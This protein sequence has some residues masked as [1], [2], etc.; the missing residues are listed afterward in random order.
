MKIKDMTSKTSLEVQDTDILVIED[1]QDTKNITVGEFKKYLGIGNDIEIDTK[2]LI[3]QTIDN[4]ISSLASAK[5]V[6]EED[7]TTVFILDVTVED[8]ACNMSISIKNSETDTYLTAEELTNLLLPEIPK[9]LRTIE[10]DQNTGNEEIIENEG[11]TGDTEGDNTENNENT[12]GENNNPEVNNSDSNEPEN[13]ETPDNNESGN[14]EI[15]DNN[16]PGNEVT[17]NDPENSNPEE[18]IPEDDNQ[19][20]DIPEQN[21]PEEDNTENKDDEIIEDTEIKTLRKFIIKALVADVYVKASSYEIIDINNKGVIKVLFDNL[22]QN[23]IAGITYDDIN[24]ALLDVETENINNEYIFNV[25]P[26]SFNN[27]VPYVENIG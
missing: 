23:E 19:E 2:K 26:D 7:N 14:E 20:E 22:T 21:E 24:I 11:N 1:A 5:Y 16:E 18:N 27:L 15:P 3:N 12:E 25:N 13:G 17:P 10:D 4:I 8:T 6:I 9:I